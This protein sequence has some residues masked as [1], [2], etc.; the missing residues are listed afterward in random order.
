L[1]R[2]SIIR[3]EH[4]KERSRGHTTDGKFLCTIQK[5]AAADPA[6]H[7]SVEQVQELLREIR[8]FFAF[9]LRVSG[10]WRNAPYVGV[11]DITKRPIVMPWSARL[12]QVFSVP[13]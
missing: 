13:R 8:S 7:V 12:R 11:E 2:P 9:H 5:L 10:M 4:L 1:H 3:L 6:M